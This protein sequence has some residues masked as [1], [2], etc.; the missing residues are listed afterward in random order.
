MKRTLIT[1]A[2]SAFLLSACVSTMTAAPA[3]AFAVKNS[4]TVTLMDG[5]THIPENLNAAKGSALTK[6]GIGLNRVHIVT[7][8]DGKKMINI[9]DKS[10]EY[11][12]YQAGSSELKQI[13]F[14]TSSLSRLG[15]EGLTTRNVTPKTIGGLDGVQFEID[16]KY[17]SGLNMKGLAALAESSSGLNVIVY[18]APASHYYQKDLAG[19]KGMIDSAQ[20]PG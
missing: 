18:V 3:G 7:I 10:Q 20:F 6:D 16:G 5:W 19:V 15:V 17:T 4:A 12:T 13:E 8:P 14:L 1:L 2:A 9:T 11:P